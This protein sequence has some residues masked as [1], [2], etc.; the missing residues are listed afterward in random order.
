MEKKIR[1]TLPDYIYDVIIADIEEFNINKN[2][3]CNYLFN[4]LKFEISQEILPDCVKKSTLQFNLNKKNLETYYEVL[5][6]NQIQVEAAFFRQIFYS[7]TNQSKKNREAFIFKEILEKIHYAIDE[8]KTLKLI[9]KD[10]KSTKVT[11]YF[12]GSSQLE[13]ANYLFSYDHLK[14]KYKNYRVA[15]I[16]SILITR[17]KI[18]QG[19]EEFINR[20]IG[21]FDPFLSKGKVVVAE[22]TERGCELLKLLKTNRP[23]VI[24]NRGNT[25]YFECSQEKAKRYFTYFLSDIKII[26][27]APL[28]QWFKDE[29]FKAYKNYI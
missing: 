2:K 8:K 24:K 10:G 6:E 13:L 17:E 9:F 27:P 20:V 19:E 11:P 3:L 18:H 12:I 28:A 25:Y 5:E 29:F 14:E 7:Y 21:D 26:E 15:N 22:L 16:K 4:E 1:V 23:H